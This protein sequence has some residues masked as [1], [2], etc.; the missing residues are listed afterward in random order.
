MPDQFS[1]VKVSPFLKLSRLINHEKLFDPIL[2]QLIINPTRKCYKEVGAKSRHTEKS[3]GTIIRDQIINNRP[4][5]F[6][7]ISNQA[8]KHTVCSI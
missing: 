1:S 4:R 3:Y 8:C 5:N 7:S 2:T 6:F